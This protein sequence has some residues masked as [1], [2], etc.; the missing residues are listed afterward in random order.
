MINDVKGCNDE[1][2]LCICVFD[3]I[4]LLLLLKKVFASLVTIDI[5]CI[6]KDCVEVKKGEGDC[7]ERRERK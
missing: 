3:I 2:Y 4:I 6:K 5:T 7:V 1:D